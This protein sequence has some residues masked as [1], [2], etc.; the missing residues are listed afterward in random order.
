MSRRARAAGAAAPRAS[1]AQAH[2]RQVRRMPL[3]PPALSPEQGASHC[4]AHCLARR[5]PQFSRR[6]RSASSVAMRLASMWP[7]PD[8]V[9][10]STCT[11]SSSSSRARPR[12]LQRST[13]SGTRRSR[14]TTC[15]RMRSGQSRTATRGT[16]SGACWRPEAHARSGTCSNATGTTGGRAGRTAGGRERV[17]SGAVDW[18]VTCILDSRAFCHQSRA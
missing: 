18:V 6:T 3:E 9:V 7:H 8:A 17:G 1:A 11:A 5:A 4:A 14:G 13:R 2:P 12:E 16:W 10:P 15:R